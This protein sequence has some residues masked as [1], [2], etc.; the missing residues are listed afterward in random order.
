MN[1]PGAN[2][3]NLHMNTAADTSGRVSGSKGNFLA[4]NFPNNPLTCGKL[5][6]VEL[7]P[8]LS[9][10]TQIFI[11]FKAHARDR[12]FKIANCLPGIVY[13]RPKTIMFNGRGEAVVELAVFGE[14][15][16]LCQPNQI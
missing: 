3:P 12:Q 13:G 9:L 11:D 15:L 14:S 1:I 5:G 8:T 10:Q 6:N 7:V 4:S 16:V 2:S